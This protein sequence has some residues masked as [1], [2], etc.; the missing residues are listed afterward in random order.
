MSLPENLDESARTVIDGNRYMTLGTSE[1]DH[2][3]R[4]SPVY[5][6]HAGYRT[7]Y[8]VSSPDARHSGNIAARPE[9]AIV[10]YDSTVEIG[11]GRA[12]YIDAVASVV[13]DEDL[14][15]RCAEAFPQADPGAVAFRPD[16]LSGDAAL[17][18]YHA[19][20]TG[21]EVHLPGRDPRNASGIDTR[22]RVNPVPPS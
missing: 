15:R 3:P 17:R 1:A 9:V 5:F 12:V 7:F 2:R 13:P 4:V 10:I 21:Y 19:D 14:P 18:L 22:R 11:Q 20:A 6:T 16:E 8:W